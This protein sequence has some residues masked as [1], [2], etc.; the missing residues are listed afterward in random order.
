[1]SRALILALLLAACGADAPP[2]PP[3]GAISGEARFGVVMR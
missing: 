3:G 1:M 2:E